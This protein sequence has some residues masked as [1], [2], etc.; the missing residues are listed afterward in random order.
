MGSADRLQDICAADGFGDL[1]QGLAGQG[2]VAAEGEQ[3]FAAEAQ[4]GQ[5]VG[6][7]VYALEVGF[8]AW[9]LDRYRYGPV[10]WLWR[11]LMYGAWQPMAQGKPA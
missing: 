1:A 9:W 5:Y 7:A 4:V 11:S 3:L 10:E 8:S 6:V 2:S